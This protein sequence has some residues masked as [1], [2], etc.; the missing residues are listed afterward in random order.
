MLNRETEHCLVDLTSK[1]A[2][3]LFSIYHMAS[4]REKITLCMKIDE[5]LVFYIFYLVKL[6]NEAHKNVAFITIKS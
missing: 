5:P 2:R 1:D 4:E 3:G 6:C